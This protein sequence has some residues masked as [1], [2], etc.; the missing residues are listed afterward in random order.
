MRPPRLAA[1]AQSICG[2]RAGEA[3][4]PVEPAP[5]GRES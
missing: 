3:W 4:Q 5:A 2:L 1:R